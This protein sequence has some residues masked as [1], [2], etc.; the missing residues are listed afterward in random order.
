MCWGIWFAFCARIGGVGP[1]LLRVALPLACGACIGRPARVC[2][3]FVLWTLFAPAGLSQDLPGPSSASPFQVIDR[4]TLV[5]AAGARSVDLPHR[6][7]SDDFPPAGGRV[8]YRMDVTLEELPKEPL[9]IYVRKLSLSGQPI[10]NGY[11]LAPCGQGPLEN[12]RCLHRPQLV[13]PPVD[14]WREGVNQLEFD[15]FA[16]GRQMNGLSTIKVGSAEA[17]HQG[18]YLFRFLWQVELLRALTWVTLALGTLALAVAWILRTETLY[19]WFGLCAITNA[20]SNLNVLVVEPLVE[21]E[22]FNWF[23]FSIR[24]I[25]VPLFLLMLLAFFERAQGWPRVILIAVAC[26]MPWITW[27]SG[28][29]RWVVLAM[30]LPMLL[31]TLVLFFAMIRWT[32]RTRDRTH[33]L[34]SLTTLI[35]ILASVLDL[36][37][38][39]GQTSFDGVYWATFALTLVFLLFGFLLTWRLA[40]ALIAERKLSTLLK[41]AARSARAAFWEWNLATNRLVWSPEMTS[42]FGL[43]DNAGVGTKDRWRDWC[44]ALHPD[45]RERAIGETMRA[46]SEHRPLAIDYRIIRPDGE[47]RWIQSRADIY[48][49]HGN[50]R[51][52]FAGICL[53]ITELK[54]NEAELVAYRDHLEDLVARRTDEL[55]SVREQL[56]RTAYELTENIPVGTYT[57][58]LHPGETLARLSFMSK[59]FLELT[60]LCRDEA[61]ASPL[62]AFAW[63]H[64]DDQVAWVEAHREAFARKAPF[65]GQA[66][67]RGDGVQRWVTAE[68]LP[69]ALSDGSSVWEGV[70][71]DVTESVRSREAVANANAALM[72]ANQELHRMA[73]TDRLTGTANRRQFEILV[74][75]EIELARKKGSPLSL[76]LFDIDHF[77]QVNDSFGHLTGDQVLV[78]VAQRVRARLRLEDLLARWGGEEFLMLLPGCP[79]VQAM[80][81]AEE[82][83]ASI[84]G[85][86]FAEAG[87]VSASF[88]IAEFHPEE[89]L[90]DWLK[91]A[92]D[93]LYEAKSSG[94]D[95]VRLGT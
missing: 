3:L 40:I 43:G 81:K 45:D 41:L 17:L 77:K 32:W 16:N 4:A 46:A 30:Y 31:A 86:P 67:V 27:A 25:T 83:R 12:L 14:L 42:L 5:T 35:T 18:P 33:M 62:G 76:I 78:E 63:V 69:R 60:G 13:I 93:A 79:A 38:L 75:A 94:R 92:D 37:R 72:V 51:V 59:R 26:I 2:V 36:M 87:W 82:L 84:R 53:D 15:I 48:L 89:R 39:G 28:N 90:D 88:G 6:L 80:E 74:A 50:K 21:I 56:E 23:V 57:M 61:L 55:R 54:K 9:G 34:V 29:N 71:I 22:L 20:L 64:P 68:S 73:T 47:A 52:E 19:L 10:L 11:R 24:L 91:R 1:W 7:V 44:A 65:F 49:D 70:L 8:R 58:V 85:T 95:R 66:R